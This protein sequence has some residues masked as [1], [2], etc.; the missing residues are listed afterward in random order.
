MLTD[1]KYCTIQCV[2][3]KPAIHLDFIYRYSEFTYQYLDKFDKSALSKK[4]ITIDITILPSIY[5][6]TKKAFSFITVLVP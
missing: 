2:Q 1:D 3:K 5:H 4:K 6:I